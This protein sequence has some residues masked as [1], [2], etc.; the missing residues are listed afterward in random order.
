MTGF[1]FT[2]VKIARSAFFLFAGLLLIPA[3]S[4]IAQEDLWPKPPPDM[5]RGSLTDTELFL[6]E[7]ALASLNMSWGDLGFR[8]DYVDDPFR[9]GVAQRAL[10]DPYS[11]VLW[12]YEWDAFLLEPKKPSQILFRA[13]SDLDADMYSQTPLLPGEGSVMAGGSYNVFPESLKQTVQDLDRSVKLAMN[14]MEQLVLGSLTSEQIEYLRGYI[15]CHFI[16]GDDSDCP[17]EEPYVPPQEFLDAMLNFDLDALVATVRELSV[18]VEPAAEGLDQH[19]NEINTVQQISINGISGP[20][21]VGS[22]GDDVWDMRNWPSY[23][24]LIDPAGND[25]YY[26]AVGAG[27]NIEDENYKSVCISIDLDGNDTYIS[28]GRSIGSGILGIGYHVDLAGDDTYRSGDFSQGCG[29][30]GGGIFVDRRG[31]DIYDA[32]A[33]V[34]GAGATGVGLMTDLS[35]NDKYSAALYAQGM[36]YVRGWGMLSDRDGFDTYWAG[37]VYDDFP[38][39]PESNISLSQGF[40]I[41]IRPA[42][43]G[44]VGILH[45]RNGNDFYSTEVYG[46]GVSYWYSVGALIDDYGNDWYESQQYSQGAGIHLS[47]GILLDRGG[48]DRYS[49]HA[50]TQGFGHDL[51]VG[52]LIDEGGSDFYTGHSLAQGSGNANGVGIFIDRGGDDGYFGRSPMDCTGHGNPARGYGSI[53]IFI[54][55]L[56]IDTYT[57]SRAGDGTWWSKTFNGVGIDVGEDWWDIQL[58]SEGLEVSRT[59][60]IPGFPVRT[61]PVVSPITSGSDAG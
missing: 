24:I 23:T 25:V 16:E 7:Q 1:A 50:C 37:G 8:K 47:S 48:I 32:G 19:K 2:T 56:G 17:D 22:R 44:G 49:S 60:A 42:A 13:A 46:Q 4:S 45:D 51:A 38:R 33:M 41:G 26:G 31:A 61:E 59:L 12:N 29:I 18:K 35:G 34:Q 53:G 43:S 27:G 28:D 10:D 36:G 57:E 55:L 40:A 30:F 14:R 11:L 9:L 15:R 52:W 54:D 21:L 3:Q 20:I 6:M 39:Y 5:A 58:D